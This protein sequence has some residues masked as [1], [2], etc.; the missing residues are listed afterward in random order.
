MRSEKIKESNIDFTIGIL[1]NS[2]FVEVNDI[3]YVDV[4]DT[5]ISGDKILYVDKTN[6]RF[7][8][9]TRRKMTIGEDSSD[10]DTSDVDT[11]VLIVCPPFDPLENIS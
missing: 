1:R 4:T 5:V 6:R 2:D 3:S 8:L 7:A 10:E 11:E 9:H